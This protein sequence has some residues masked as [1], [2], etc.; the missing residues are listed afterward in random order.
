MKK[1]LTLLLLGIF[2]LSFSSALLSDNIISYYKFD[3]TSGVVIDSVGN[4]N[5]TTTGTQ[6]VNGFIEK[7]VNYTSASTYNSLQ[8]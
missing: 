4:Y 8:D 7:A 6:N 2:M 3:E 5:G 1:L